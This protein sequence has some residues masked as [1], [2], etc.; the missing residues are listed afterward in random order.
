LPDDL[1][2][3]LALRE[4]GAMGDTSMTNSLVDSR[5]ESSEAIP[6]NVNLYSAMLA[7]WLN[8]LSDHCSS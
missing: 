7:D 4:I 1:Q 6:S 2:Q 8:L 3:L 5:Q